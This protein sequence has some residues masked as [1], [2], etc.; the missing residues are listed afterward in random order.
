MSDV[1]SLHTCLHGSDSNYDY[2]DNQCTL[3][4]DKQMS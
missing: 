3:T 1:V 4:E 2:I